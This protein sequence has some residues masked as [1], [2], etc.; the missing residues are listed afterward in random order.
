MPLS[1]LRS[2]TS[3]F[4]RAFSSRSFSKDFWYGRNR[5]HFVISC[6]SQTDTIEPRPGLFWAIDHMMNAFLFL[7]LLMTSEQWEQWRGSGSSGISQN[8]HL[9]ESWS[10]TENIAWK[11]EVPGRGFSSPVVRGDRIFLTTSTEGPPIA[12]LKGA[13]HIY[14]NELFVHPDSVGADRYYQLLVL[15]YRANDGKL[16]WKRLAYDG[17]V[18]EQ[19]HKLNSYATPTPLVDSS[20]VFA[21]FGSEGLYAYDLDGNLQWKASVGPLPALGIGV[22]G[23]PAMDNER[24]FVQCDLEERQ[25]SFVTAIEKKS[26]KQLWRTSRDA[27]I[28]GEVT[29]GWSTPLVVA[30]ELV[31]VGSKSLSGYARDTGQELWHSTKGVLGIPCASAVAGHGMVFAQAGVPDKRVVAV[32][33]GGRGEVTPRWT[34]SKGSGYVPSPI[35]FGDYLYIIN[36]AGLLTCLDALTG[37]PVY[38]GKRPTSPGDYV[39]SPVAFRGRLFI[40]NTDGD[41]TV[42]AAGPK[43]EIVRTN[44]LGEPVFASF[45]LV[46]SSIIVRAEHHLYKIASRKVT[47]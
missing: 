21:Y 44:S 23:S 7:S 27:N 18:F 26:G 1:R 29:A 16:L 37:A 19:R 42:V 28:H 46:G 10:Q 31:L 33:L 25:Q 11:V 12:G 17:P 13:T 41:T 39:S 30:D 22:A 36:D 4:S 14:L 38:E 2:A 9:P 6:M 35:L 3:F 20:R 5:P 45:A 34:Y 24:I 47:E 15:C 32:P 40:T 8:E 43:H